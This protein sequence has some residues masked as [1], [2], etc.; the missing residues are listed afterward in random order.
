MNHGLFHGQKGNDNMKI[1]DTTRERKRICDF[2]KGTVFQKGSNFLMKTETINTS[3][4]SCNAVRLD[5]G[6]IVMLPIDTVVIP[7]DCE[8]IIK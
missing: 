4:F 2:E 8:L 3:G 7:L 1:I 6:N 5:N